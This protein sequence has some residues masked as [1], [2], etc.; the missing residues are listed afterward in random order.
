MALSQRMRS[1]IYEGLHEIIG[2]EEAEAL[3]AQ[4]PSRD[5]DET[6]R[7]EHLEV[8]LSDLR[9]DQARLRVEIAELR[10][11]VTDKVSALD[12][13]ISLLDARISALDARISALEARMA[14][15]FRA[16]ATLM[17]ALVA[18]GTT[19]TSAVAAF[20]G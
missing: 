6:L 17:V 2:E 12:A 10:V 14:D 18:A 20:A 4:F 3:L 5:V 9:V 1:S 11:E 13:R 19:I 16:Q 7:R 8:G 15:R